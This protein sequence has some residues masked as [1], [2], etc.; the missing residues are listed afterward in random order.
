MGNPLTELF[1]EF[2][3]NIDQAAAEVKKQLETERGFSYWCSDKEAVSAFEAHK[4]ALGP[5]IIE[6]LRV[7]LARHDLDLMAAFDGATSMADR[8]VSLTLIDQT[9]TKL[10]SDLH[11]RLMDYFVDRGLA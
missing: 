10:P 9:G 11:S 6:L 2:E 8:G 3:L 5:A 4:E 1:R 7:H